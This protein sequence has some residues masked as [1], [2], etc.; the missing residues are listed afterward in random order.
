MR[1]IINGSDGDLGDHGEMRATSPEKFLKEALCFSPKS[2]VCTIG[3]LP[4][5]DGKAK[6]FF[7]KKAGENPTA[8]SGMRGLTLK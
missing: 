3:G 4:R 7:Y 8:C 1:I 2:D 5:Q 6:R